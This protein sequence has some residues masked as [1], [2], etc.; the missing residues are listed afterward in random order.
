MGAA[1]REPKD[2]DLEQVCAMVQGVKALGLETC[3]TLGMLTDAQAQRLEAPG[4]TT[5][6]TTSTPRRISTARSSPRALPGAAR[7]AGAVRDAGIQVCC[8]GIVGMGES[9]D[10]RAGMLATLAN[11]PQHPESV[12]INLLVQVE[13]TPLSGTRSSIRSTSCAPSRSRAS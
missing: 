13:G 7:H 9:D 10:D 5:T 8:G 1:W 2:R 11:L 12:P 6:T 3:A 4:S